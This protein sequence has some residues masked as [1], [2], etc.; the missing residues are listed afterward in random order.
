MGLRGGGLLV[1]MVVWAVAVGAESRLDLEDPSRLLVGVGDRYELTTERGKKL[2]LAE[3]ARKNGISLDLLQ[4]WLTRDWQDD[5]LKPE[6][7]RR[8][9]AEGITPVVVHY[10][11]G[12]T[13]SKERVEAER[14]AWYESLW[15]MAQR[16]KMDAPV[17]VI[18]EPEFNVK[19]PAGQTAV[20]DWPWF[21][22]Y[23][24][25]AAR[26]IRESAPNALVGAC[27]GDFPGPPG[28]ERVLGPVANDL[29]FLAFQEMRGVT[30][31]DRGRSGY[32]DVGRSAVR[33]ARY[34]DRAFGRPI[35]L[36]YVA[37]S[38]Y[39]GWEKRQAHALRD[40]AKRKQELLDANVFGIVYFQ[41]RDDPAHTGYFGAA[42]PHFGLIRADGTPKPAL[43]PFRELSTRPAR[44]AD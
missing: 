28:L 5:W 25:G 36:G 39:G 24:R 19:P 32:T 37:F 42:E 8:L 7:L 34:L 15:R 17:L 41:L 26:V 13:I 4:V 29:D 18:L 38:S 21:A 22:D 27:P 2:R 1:V 35:L 6:Q 23:L 31:P 44:A 9:S 40:I 12:D 43:A 33:F 10:Y 3:A 14:D 11:W 20:T 16:I 30:D